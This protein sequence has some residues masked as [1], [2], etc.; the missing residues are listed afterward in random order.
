MTEASGDQVEEKQARLAERSEARL[1]ES[2][3]LHK[4][5]NSLF[6]LVKV[7]NKLTFLWGS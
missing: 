6:R 4:I 5:V 7:N 1:L 2:Q 3:L